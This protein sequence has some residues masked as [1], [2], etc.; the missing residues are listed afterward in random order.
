MVLK[1]EVKIGILVVFSVLL[2]VGGILFYKLYLVGQPPPAVAEA[3]KEPPAKPAPA[4]AAATAPTAAP[5]AAPAP[6]APTRP[7]ALPTAPTSPPSAAPPPVPPLAPP[8]PVV[9][10]APPAAPPEEPPALSLP[11]ETA[12]AALA[13][14]R[15][16]G[17]QT[18][19]LI[20][21]AA[22]TARQVAD[23]PSGEA[24]PE[25]ILSKPFALKEENAGTDE[26]GPSARIGTVTPRSAAPPTA[27]PAPDTPSPPRDARV[28]SGSPPTAPASPPPADTGGGTKPRPP[29]S[30]PGG[31]GSTA[32]A[33]TDL[34]PVPLKPL[35]PVEASRPLTPIAPDE[36]SR[37]TS[38]IPPRFERTYDPPA[39]PEKPVAEHTPTR[40]ADPAG[41]PP[42]ASPPAAS[43]PA[44]LR[45][46]ETII[47]GVPV[48]V[49]PQPNWAG[50]NTPRRGV[51]VVLTGPGQSGGVPVEAYDVRRYLVRPGDTF[52]SISQ[53]YYHTDR[54]Q[55]ALAQY[56]REQDPS[57]ETL[58]PGKIVFLPQADYL[59]R[60][61]LTSSAGRAAPAGS[62]AVP[63]V[64]GT[65]AHTLGPPVSRYAPGLPPGTTAREAAQA[66][67][68]MPS[69]QKL[70]QVRPNDTIW[71]IAK[72][73]LG[74][75]ERW[76]E[77]L[78][79][80]RE[81]LRDVNQL[82]VGMTLRLPD[83]AKLDAALAP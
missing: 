83:D 54:Y 32:A 39:T 59:E 38:R 62:A 47:N 49:R 5:P 37:A 64:V 23:A 10:T 35:P 20:R 28:A 34:P 48:T 8:P 61:Y 53:S 12:E 36:A 68:T 74:D 81:Q 60:R 33:P 66:D 58:Q 67:W 73:T 26:D 77:I 63:P 9:S 27:P 42:S 43:T 44:P 6:T 46:E 31:S 52:A 30:P 51:P 76:P 55:D 22:W 45:A 70:Y 69:G 41:T 17:R 29:A 3:G 11:K 80:N 7:P 57:L 4:P 15:A 72:R 24:A 71:A 25:Q 56:N 75:G 50:V 21:A 78:R 19:A 13:A 65:P 14:A 79:L 82:R 16:S 2:L 18:A 40:T 1:R